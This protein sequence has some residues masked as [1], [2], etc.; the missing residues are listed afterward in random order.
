MAASQ[1]RSTFVTVVAWIFIAL[2]GYLTFQFLIINLMARLIPLPGWSGETQGQ[3]DVVFRT[4]FGHLRLLCFLMLLVSLTALASSIGL[5][6]RKNWAR[7]V[8]I[9]FLGLGVVYQVVCI[10]VLAVMV[11]AEP[12]LV[13]DDPEAL[14]FVAAIGVVGLAMILTVAALLVWII[15]RLISPAVRAEFQPVL[16]AETGAGPTPP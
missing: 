6:K 1:Q 14:F 9:G 2:T 12:D 3:M 15:K 7:R 16:G 5:L 11:F 10:G 4:I 8:F 13:K